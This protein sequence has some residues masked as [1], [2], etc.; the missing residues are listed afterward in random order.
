MN[1]QRLFDVNNLEGGRLLAV[2]LLLLTYLYIMSLILDPQCSWVLPEAYIYKSFVMQYIPLKNTLKGAFNNQ[3]FEF[4]ERITRPFSSIFEIVDT[5]FRAWLWQYITPISSL[6]LTFIFSLI[7]GPILYYK[8]LINI[9]I[10]Q[11]IAIFA[12]VIM[13]LNP[14]SLSLVVMLFRPAKVMMNFFY[15]FCLYYSVRCYQSENEH[16]NN[17]HF[18]LLI[19]L[20]ILTGFLFDETAIVIVISLLC[21]FPKIFLG[22]FKRMLG[23]S[24]V[25]ITL[26]M[27]YLIVFPDLAAYYGYAKPNLLSYSAVGAPTFPPLNIIFSNLAKN[28]Q[29]I[30]VESLGIFNPFKMQ[31]LKNKLLFG[32]LSV[33]CVT[34]ICSF[35]W[36]EARKTTSYAPEI[37]KY[38]IKTLALLIILYVFHTVLLDSV[39]NPVDGRVWGPY[40]Y[41][42]YFGIVWGLM[43]GLIGEGISQI[44]QRIPVNFKLLATL[45]TFSLMTA[46]PYTNFIYRSYH[47]YPFHPGNIEDQYRD[48]INR[49]ALYNP[50]IFGDKKIFHDI[51][52]L[53]RK[54]II[55][56]TIPKEYYWIPVEMGVLNNYPIPSSKV[57]TS[58]VDTVYHLP[59]QN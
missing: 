29:D 14:G 21:L 36:I 7:L 30:T 49:F 23:F 42:S 27:L 12:T 19:G 35:L 39:G 15:I 25:P 31:N 34:F 24:L 2:V 40:W 52:K 20:G 3:I 17:N 59:L 32:A 8:F 26:I 6:S 46:F 22:N 56:K 33:S 37:K 53:N 9:K 5:H 18:L 58:N 16:K 11:A 38:I 28:S 51:W 41:G 48:T 50:S 43:V 1:E 4:S 44:K 13:L 55:P 54:G 47:F 10:R 57:L 45:L